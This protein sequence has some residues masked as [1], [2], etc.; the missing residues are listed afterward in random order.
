MMVDTERVQGQLDEITDV[1][2]DYKKKLGVNLVP[3]ELNFTNI[4]PAPNAYNYGHL[5]TGNCNTLKME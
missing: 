2:Y 5:L 1:I 3:P 4:T